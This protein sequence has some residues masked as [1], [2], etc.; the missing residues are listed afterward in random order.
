MRRIWKNIDGFDGYQV[1]NRGEVRSYLDRNYGLVDKPHFLKPRE[2]N[3]FGHSH[4][5]LYKDKIQYNKSLHRIVAKAFLPNPNN[6]PL[7]RHLNNNPRD[8][9]VENLAWGTYKDNTKDSIDTGTFHYNYHNFTR[10]EIEKSVETNRTPVKAIDIETGEEQCYK[11]Q[12]E[13]ARCLHLSQGNINM[14][15]NGLRRRAG[16]YTF[17]YIDKEEFN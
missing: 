7:V 13:A 1:S 9:R 2:V 6:Y 8:N 15:L 11:S 10:D 3:E 17:E 4:V 14:A 12:Q 5:A 16:N